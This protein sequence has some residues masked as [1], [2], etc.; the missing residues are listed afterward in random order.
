MTLQEFAP[1]IS[2]ALTICITLLALAGRIGQLIAEARRD[3]ANL[4]TDVTELKTAMHGLQ[5]KLDEVVRLQTQHTALE[6]RLDDHLARIQ[7]LEN[8]R[9]YS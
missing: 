7:R 3:V 6:R 2:A 5:P 1:A 9:V 8:G 4:Q